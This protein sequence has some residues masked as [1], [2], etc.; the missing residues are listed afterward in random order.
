MSTPLNAQNSVNITWDFGTAYELFASL[1]AFNSPK[2]HGIRAGWAAGVRSRIPEKE[3]KLLED[4]YMFVCVPWA[5]IHSLPA[6]KDAV[7]A[8][9][10]LKQIPPAERLIEI[11]CIDESLPEAEA[12]KDIL[13]RIFLRVARTGAWETADLHQALTHWDKKEG[14][15][16]DTK[17]LTRFL[18]WCARPAEL[19]ELFLSALQSYYQAFF[20]DE[21]KRIGPVLQAGLER[22]QALAS[23]LTLEEFFL[24]ISRG[25]QLSEKYRA[26]NYIIAPAFWT[27]PLLSHQ[28]FDKNTVFLLF[29]ARPVNMAAI[30]GEEA[31]ED[32]VRALKALADPT[33]LR[34]LRYLSTEELAPSELARRLRLRAPTITHHLKELRLA[35]LVYLDIQKKETRYRIRPEAFSLMD[36]TLKKHLQIGS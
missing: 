24:E 34:I 16:Q 33:R 27:T 15:D 3:R 19:G 8:L 6:P 35:G 36:D 12:E 5:W 14:I 20:E 22:A 10:V 17:R 32:L 2:Y 1:Y 13:D 23:R 28:K 7:S 21:E 26:A 18:D 31:P 9:W 30:P 11:L 4:A 25:I 29:G